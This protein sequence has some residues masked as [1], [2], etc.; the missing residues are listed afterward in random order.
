QYVAARQ[1][2]ILPFEHLHFI[3]IQRS[4]TL[5]QLHAGDEQPVIV[6]QPILRQRFDVVPGNAD[7]RL[8]G[9]RSRRHQR[10]YGDEPEQ[11]MPSH[12]SSLSVEIRGYHVRCSSLS[13]SPSRKIEPATTMC[14]LSFHASAKAIVTVSAT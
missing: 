13:T 3:G 5:R 6:I 4:V 8:G 7:C 1:H 2:P 9:K 10:P 14:G 12:S 11:K